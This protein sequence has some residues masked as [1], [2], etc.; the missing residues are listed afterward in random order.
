MDTDDFEKGDRVAWEEEG[1]PT[2]FGEVVGFDGENPVVL[3]DL[4]NEEV[5]CATEDLFLTA[6]NFPKS[7][8]E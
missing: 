4:T 6:G 1:R 5:A 7:W 3:F 8:S 2:R